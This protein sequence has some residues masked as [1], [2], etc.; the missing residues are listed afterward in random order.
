MEG[1]TCR[2]IAFKNNKSK[3]RLENGDDQSQAY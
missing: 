1:N 3:N 2:E